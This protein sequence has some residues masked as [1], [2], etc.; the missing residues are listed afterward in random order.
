MQ[1]K[2]YL[3]KSKKEKISYLTANEVQKSVINIEVL[4]NVTRYD[5]KYTKDFCNKMDTFM[6]KHYYKGVDLRKARNGSD[7]ERSDLAELLGISSHTIKQMQTN[8]K[9]LSEDAVEFIKTAGF[10]KTVPLKKSKKK[11]L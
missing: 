5:F 9:P 6:E 2:R 4:E 11:G 8:K 1:L 10:K 3:K 7:L